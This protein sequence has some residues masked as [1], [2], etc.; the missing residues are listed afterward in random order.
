[1]LNPGTTW[2]TQY[3]SFFLMFSKVT[4]GKEQMCLLES[5]LAPWL[6]IHSI[7]R[8]LPTIRHILANLLCISIPLAPLAI[9]RWISN[10]ILL[11]SSKI[12]TDNLVL[13]EVL[14]IYSL[15]TPHSQSTGPLHNWNNR[16]G[17]GEYSSVVE[18]VRTES[19]WGLDYIPS[20][21]HTHTERLL[22]LCGALNGSLW[23]AKAMD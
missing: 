17:L 1:M 12:T 3:L 22:K 18:W 15:N 19:M 14:C 10:L 13:L 2:S 9:C 21:T 6:A 8:Y 20:T 16:I 23:K 11:L 7:G 4:K 5:L